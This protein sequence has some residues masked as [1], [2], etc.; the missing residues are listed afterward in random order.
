MV[1]TLIT[2]KKMKQMAK[3]DI[4]FCIDISGSMEPCIA[5]VK[6]NIHGFIDLI[7]K[8]PEVTIDWRLGFLAHISLGFFVRE[9]TTD[10]QEFRRALDSLQTGGDEANLPA[11]DLCLDFPWRSDAH[12]FVIMFTDEGVATGWEP[13]QSRS[14]V[15]QL[16]KKIMDIGASVY[17][18]AIDAPESDDYRRIATANKCRF[19]GIPASSNFKVVNFDEMLAKLGKSVSTGSRGIV[20]SQQSVMNDLYGVKN[21][22]C[23]INT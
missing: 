6:Q 14:K 16:M 15:D 7:E 9:F 23:K 21:F 2:P 22:V 20:S 11:L 8:D 12:K 4:V 19:I 18:I 17:I 5:G 3:T 13:E 10:V 1:Q